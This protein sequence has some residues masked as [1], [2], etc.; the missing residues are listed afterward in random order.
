MKTCVW[1]PTKCREY[2]DFTEK[3]AKSTVA[4]SMWC[5]LNTRKFSRHSL[6]HASIVLRI[7]RNSIFYNGQELLKQQESAEPLGNQQNGARNSIF[8]SGQ[9]LLKQQDSAEPLGNHQKRSIQKL[10]KT[11]ITFFIFI[12][13]Y[14]FILFF[15]F[16]F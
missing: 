11:K 13:F 2:I 10:H 3:R 14:F 6:H 12:Y 9:E 7:Y 1:P 8:C 4:K 16:L 5:T 15:I